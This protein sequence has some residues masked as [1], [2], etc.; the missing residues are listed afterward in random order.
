MA[1]RIYAD[2]SDIELLIGTDNANKMRSLF[3]GHTVYVPQLDQRKEREVQIL[4]A[5]Y[6]GLKVK[7]IAR[8]INRR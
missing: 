1:R 7:E 8:F 3:G 5:R 4:G 6:R 2:F